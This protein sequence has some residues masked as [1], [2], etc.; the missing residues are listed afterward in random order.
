MYYT[1]IPYLNN[2][3]LASEAS[4]FFHVKKFLK[5]SFQ[6]LNG[7]CCS[8]TVRCNENIQADN[9]FQ[10]KAIRICRVYVATRTTR[11]YF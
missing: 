4:S 2:Y 1:F 9:C 3:V 11:Q 6:A 8:S 7:H 10:Y 5:I